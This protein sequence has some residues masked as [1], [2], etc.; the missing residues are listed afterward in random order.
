[1]VPC[2]NF[3]EENSIGLS[4]WRLENK[5]SND[6]FKRGNKT[7]TGGVPTEYSIYTKNYMSRDET[8]VQ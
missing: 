1:M 4:S 5:G 3:H 7:L 8:L 2:T 6:G